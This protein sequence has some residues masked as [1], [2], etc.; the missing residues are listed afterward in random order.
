M[1]IG[2][3]NL[4]LYWVC[5][6]AIHLRQKAFPNKCVNWQEKN[7]SRIYLQFNGNTSEIYVVDL[8]YVVVLTLIFV[9][10][11]ILWVFSRKTDADFPLNYRFCVRKKTKQKHT[12]NNELG[13][14]Q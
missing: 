10:L 1:A 8:I 7:E 12:S 9:S 5:V 6:E 2:A 13:F 11:C 4:V 3:I 14:L